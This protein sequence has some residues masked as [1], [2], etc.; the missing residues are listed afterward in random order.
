MPCYC[1]HNVVVAIPTWPPLALRSAPKDKAAHSRSCDHGL[2]ISNTAQKKLYIESRSAQT[3]DG[4]GSAACFHVSTWPLQAT[5]KVGN[6]WRVAR[7]IVPIDK[8]RPIVENYK[9][10]L[11]FERRNDIGSGVIE[12]PF[13][14]LCDE[15]ELADPLNG[16]GP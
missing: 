1:E 6:T 16:D 10:S 7:R 14:L 5:I 12:E 11:T 2:N 4:V 8:K 3:P 15:L 13:K 9:P